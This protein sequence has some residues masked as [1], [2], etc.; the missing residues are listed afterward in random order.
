MIYINTEIYLWPAPIPT[1]LW[2]A[3]HK[4][5]NKKHGVPLTPACGGAGGWQSVVSSTLWLKDPHWKTGGRAGGAR[6]KGG[7]RERR[8][9]RKREKEG[10]RKKN[11]RRKGRE[12]GGRVILPPFH[13][14]ACI[15]EEPTACT[16]NSPKKPCPPWAPNRSC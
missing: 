3:R 1:A 16:A 5:K 9:G 8:K 14:L 7:R 6:R 12:G 13:S 10:R 4:C 2:R 11:R 15:Q